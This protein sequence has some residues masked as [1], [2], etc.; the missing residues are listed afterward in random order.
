M[1]KNSNNRRYSKI[2]KQFAV[3]FYFYSLKYCEYAQYGSNF[4]LAFI[5]DFILSGM[6]NVFEKINKQ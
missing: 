5:L 2:I 3:M 6:E 4:T 1:L